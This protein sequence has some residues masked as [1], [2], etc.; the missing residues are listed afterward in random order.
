MNG[1]VRFCKHSKHKTVLPYM[2]QYNISIPQSYSINT[3]KMV[4]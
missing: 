3:I 2:T 4:F 1:V